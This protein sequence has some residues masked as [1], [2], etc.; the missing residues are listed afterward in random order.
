[1][2]TIDIGTSKLGQGTGHS[3]IGDV[4]KYGGPALTVTAFEALAG[5]A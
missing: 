2:L 1:M 4:E 3:A 5:A